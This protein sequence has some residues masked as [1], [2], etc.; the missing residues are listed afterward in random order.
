[1]TWR[2]SLIRIAHHEVDTLQRRLAEIVERRGQAEIR[3]ALLQAEA[4]AEA[5]G[6]DHSAETSRN[7]ADFMGGV[8]LRRGVLQAAIAAIAAEESGARD[9]LAQAFESLKKF[10][11]V[12]EMARVADEKESARRDTLVLDEVGMR[13]AR[14]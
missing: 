7:L 3:L 11:Q 10:E 6:A 8:R 1:M 14:R 2:Q 5:R 12:A 13:A 4:E 9:A